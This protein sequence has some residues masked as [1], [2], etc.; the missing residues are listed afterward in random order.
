MSLFGKEIYFGVERKL[1]CK[2]VF[3]E[4]NH[5]YIKKGK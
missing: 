1:T 5:F 4:E 2:K 3:E